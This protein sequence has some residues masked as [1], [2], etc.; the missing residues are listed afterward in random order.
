MT[1]TVTHNTKEEEL[2]AKLALELKEKK[3]KD[4]ADI[5]QKIA[6]DKD[7][8]KQ[9]LAKEKIAEYDKLEENHHRAAETQTGSSCLILCIFITLGICILEHFIP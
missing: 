5:E 2:L 8:A 3:A 7:L 1:K 4:K 6:D 9:Q